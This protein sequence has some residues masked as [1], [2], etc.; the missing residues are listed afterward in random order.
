MRK[1][2]FRILTM[3]LALPMLLG[4]VS[5]KDNDDK[6]RRER[7][8]GDRG[9]ARRD[10][11]HHRPMTTRVSADLHAAVM[12]NFDEGSTGAALVKRLPETSA[13]ID[14][15]TRLVVLSGA[16]FSMANPTTTAYDMADVARVYLGGGYIA[17]VQP[18]QEQAAF[19]GLTLL[20]AV[21]GLEVEAY[22]QMFDLDAPAAA[23]AASHSDAAERLKARAANLQHAAATRAGGD[24]PQA[25]CAEII[26]LGPT[27][28][29]MQDALPDVA[30]AYVHTAD[31]EGNE[32]APQAVTTRTERTPYTSG[33]LAAAAAD[34]LNTVEQQPTA[35]ARRTATRASGSTAVNELMDASE[36]FT[37]CGAIDYRVNDNRTYQSPNRVTTILRSWGIHNMESNK[38]YYYL[39][40]NVTLKMDGLYWPTTDETYWYDAKNFGEYTNW[41]GSFLSQYETSM[42]LTGDGSIF[43]EASVPNTDNNSQS[44]SV[45]IGSSTSHTVTNGYSVGFSGGGSPAGGMGSINIGG[46]HSEGTTEG[47]SFSMSMSQTHKDFGVKK[48]TSGNKVTWTY[49]G[50]LPKYYFN[51]SNRYNCH[52]WP[53]DILVND[54]DVADEICW[55]VSN[56][57]GQYTVDVTSAPQTAAL[58]YAKNSGSAGNRP[59]KHE[60]TTTPTE[61][62]SHQL[63]EPNRA[64]QNW[65]MFVTIDEWEGVPVAGAQ[66]ELENSI[67]RAFSSVFQHEF[68]V[69]DKTAT[70]L[71]TI[72]YVINYS[73][74]LFS[75]NIDILLS[76][77][78][79]WGI[80]RFTIHWRCDDVNVKTRDGFTVKEPCTFTATDGTGD[81]Y[82]NIF[83]GNPS[84]IWRT[85]AK[86]DGIWYVEFKGSRII[87]PT[88]YTLTTGAYTS[89]YPT[90][91]PKTWKLMAKLNPT[92]A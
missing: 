90:E 52:Q 68:S 87:T 40:Q 5:C 89:T 14:L 12:A 24:D 10:A 62:Y 31:A 73:K 72:T 33:L 48:N 85:S 6:P 2:T 77:G 92:D 55:S 13:A 82:G 76:Y 83:D 64:M 26:I 54:C 11:A 63:I 57:S 19:F 65:R 22:E 80:S 15:D 16:D 7:R 41:F 23:R 17:L 74:Q 35:A 88:A 27:D 78:K 18:T 61:T 46:N 70:S 75:Q 60:Y 30:T 58:L 3:L 66:G 29:F 38:D 91:R 21:A 45:S 51:T 79:S 20:T 34:W 59:H 69:A 36:T 53:A 86:K 81:G 4:V 49:N 84:T 43:L 42:N 32:T 1:A 9:G 25:P 47:T 39:K 44:T 37:H 50:T 56:P 28:Y 8:D 71:N 67:E